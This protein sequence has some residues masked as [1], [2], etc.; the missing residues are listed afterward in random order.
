MELQ[1]AQFPGARSSARLSFVPWR[2]ISVCPHYV[3]CFMSPFWRLEFWGG[4][5]IFGKLCTP[6]WTSWP[7]KM[8]QLCCLKMRWTKHPEPWRHI[9]EELIPHQ[10]E[11]LKLQ[12]N[13][14]VPRTEFIAQDDKWD[15]KEWR[16]KKWCKRKQLSCT[17][18][19]KN[20]IHLEQLQTTSKNLRHYS[21]C[22]CVISGTKDHKVII[23]AIL[24]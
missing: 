1:G 13:S 19:Y 23:L 9:P 5:I 15:D 16:Q 12:F 21:N 3:T 20:S 10:C 11:N 4:S 17:P 18:S 2:L 22:K 14:P 8:I 6:L 7:L 24:L